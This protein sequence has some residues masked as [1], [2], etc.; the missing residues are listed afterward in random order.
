MN[1]PG[2]FFPPPRLAAE[3]PT[4]G[5]MPGWILACFCKREWCRPNKICKMVDSIPK[6]ALRSLNAPDRLWSGSGT[7]VLSAQACGRGRMSL[8]CG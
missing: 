1:I 3:D 6:W 4:F 7:G 5:L 2:H 8:I